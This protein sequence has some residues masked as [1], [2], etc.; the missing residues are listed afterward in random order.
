MWSAT[1]PKEVQGLAKDFLKEYI[2]VTIGSL[3]LKVSPTIFNTVK[4]IEEFKKSDELLR[5]L[6]NQTRGDRIIIFTQTK[7][8]ADSL[9]RQLRQR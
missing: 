3:E 9:T 2:Q 7:K 8:G 5:V 4:Y 6:K 1:W